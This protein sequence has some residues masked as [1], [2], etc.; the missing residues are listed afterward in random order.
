LLKIEEVK[1]WICKI[2]FMGRYIRQIEYESFSPEKI[3]HQWI[4]S[5]PEVNKLLSEARTGL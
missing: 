3:N 4:I 5:N 2:L 1:L